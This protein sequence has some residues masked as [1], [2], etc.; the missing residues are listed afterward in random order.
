MSRKSH[1]SGRQRELHSKVEGKIKYIRRSG[2][3][4]G[5][6]KR[7]QGIENG[8]HE[9]YS[10]FLYNV[11]SMLGAVYLFQRITLDFSLRNTF[12]GKL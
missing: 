1:N 4:V 2:R 6:N 7:I 10:Y 12:P 5:N 8:V 9:S 3:S 11:T